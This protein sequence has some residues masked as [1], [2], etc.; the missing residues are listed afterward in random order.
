MDL[1]NINPGLKRGLIQPFTITMGQRIFFLSYD[2]QS[3][4]ILW[5][6]FIEDAEI[7]KKIEDSLRN[8]LTN[9]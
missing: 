5:N 3:N 7:K 6:M 8:Y 1:I 4:R 2:E 9:G